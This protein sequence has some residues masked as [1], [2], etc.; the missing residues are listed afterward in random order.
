MARRNRNIQTYRV[1][2]LKF[3]IMG[4]RPTIWRRVFVPEDYTLTDLHNVIQAVFEWS[5]CR[6]W[7]FSIFGSVVD[8]DKQLKD[9]LKEIGQQMLYIYDIADNWQIV[10]QLQ[11]IRQA[12]ANIQYPICTAGR[13]ARPSEEVGGAAGHKYIQERLKADPNSQDYVDAWEW[14]RDMDLPHYYLPGY[15]FDPESVLN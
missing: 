13:Q 2:Q 10:V 15:R 1:Y 8:H 5:G 3:L 6:F 9:I 4:I 11:A 14:I 7:Q 12:K